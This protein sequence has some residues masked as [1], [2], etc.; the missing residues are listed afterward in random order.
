MKSMYVYILLCSDESYYIGVTN[1]LELRFEQHIQGINTNCYTYKK[2]PLKLVYYELFNDSKRLQ[3][4]CF[5]ILTNGHD[6]N[7]FS[8]MKL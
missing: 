5:A 6:R 8:C 3:G 1:N 7:S 4:I 2:R